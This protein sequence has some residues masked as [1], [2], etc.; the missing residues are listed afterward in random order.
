MLWVGLKSCT[1]SRSFNSLP[2]ILAEFSPHPHR[3][4]RSGQLN[5]DSE[6]C[7][8]WSMCSD[9]IKL[10]QLVDIIK[11][12]CALPCSN[13]ACIRTVEQLYAL[14]S[15]LRWSW[16]CCSCSPP[17][18][19][20]CPGG[21]LWESQYGQAFLAVANDFSGRFALHAALPSTITP[22]S[23]ALHSTAWPQAKYQ[24]NMQAAS[25]EKFP[26]LGNLPFLCAQTPQKI[27]LPARTKVCDICSA[28]YGSHLLA[29]KTPWANK[30]H[31]HTRTHLIHHNTY[32][33]TA[34]ICLSS[35]G[36]KNK[37]YRNRPQ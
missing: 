37:I 5:R 11:P 2:R 1:F 3:P 4:D 21:L 32:D 8:R 25:D 9:G 16:G 27:Q 29:R 10:H 34:V 14:V 13:I 12:K 23:L 18:L 7:N 36:I 24:A 30:E 15:F 33:I 19:S 35:D 26:T 17:S 20:C 28:T 31:K 22:W 6:E